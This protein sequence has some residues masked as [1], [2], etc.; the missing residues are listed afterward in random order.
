MNTSFDGK[1][2]L[3]AL[4]RRVAGQIGE[5]MLNGQRRADAVKRAIL[6]RLN[7]PQPKT[8]VDARLREDRGCCRAGAPITEGEISEAA[9]LLKACG[10]VECQ[11]LLLASRKHLP[12]HIENQGIPYDGR[13]DRSAHIGDAGIACPRT[14]SYVVLRTT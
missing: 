8:M 1:V 6:T 3:A 11:C 9:E 14:T 4:G 12:T 2:T 10:Y 5:S 7:D 13:Q